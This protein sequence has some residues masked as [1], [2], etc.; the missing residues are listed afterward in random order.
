MAD[1]DTQWRVLAAHEAGHVVALH[2]N[3]YPIDHVRMWVDGAIARGY[4]ETDADPV[5][6]V[7]LAGLAAGD[8]AAPR[9]YL[10]GACDDIPD[11]KAALRGTRQSLWS[12]QADA[13]RWVRRE[14]RRIARVAAVLERE[15]GMSGRQ[16]ARLV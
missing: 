8:R 2:L 5:A 14:W 4:T 1:I 16:A 13:R 12:A 10:Q 9:G 6:L 15:G 3:G 7:F 11:A